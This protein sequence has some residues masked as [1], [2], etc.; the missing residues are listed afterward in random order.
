[1]VEDRTNAPAHCPGPKHR[2][3]GRRA[4]PDAP[5][6]GTA[7]RKGDSPRPRDLELAGKVATVGRGIAESYFGELFSRTPMTRFWG[8]S[9]TTRSSAGHREGIDCFDLC[10]PNNRRFLSNLLPAPSASL[11]DPQGGVILPPQACRDARFFALL[12]RY[13]CSQDRWYSLPQVTNLFL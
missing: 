10:F 8:Q 7:G 9:H 6:V 13:H 5:A 3:T 11:A 1:M 2:G 4:L 12:N